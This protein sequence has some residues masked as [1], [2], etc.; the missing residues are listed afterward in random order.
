MMVQL[1]NTDAAWLLAAV[2]SIVSVHGES[3]SLHLCLS[4]GTTPRPVYEKLAQAEGFRALVASRAVHLWVGDEREAPEHSDLRNSDMIAEIF[5]AAGLDFKT[6]AFREVQAAPATVC[7][8][9]LHAWPTGPRE[10]A[11]VFYE[12]ELLAHAGEADAAGSPW[13]DLV[14]LGMGQDGHTAGLFTEEDIRRGIEGEGSAE[15]SNHAILLTDTPQEPKRRMTMAPRVLLSSRKILVL[16]RGLSKARLLMANVFDERADPIKYF[17]RDSC[18][19]V[20]Q[21]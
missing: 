15:H 7:G 3:Q 4:G 16:I 9:F 12:K 11:A 17:L 21:I 20:A 13:F 2:T 5:A 1:H 8:L 19:I 14:V 6:V 10:R 18:E